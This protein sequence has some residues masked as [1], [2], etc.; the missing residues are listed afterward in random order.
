MRTLTSTR[1]I[2]MQTLKDFMPD[3][4]VGSQV[5]TT[6]RLE[7]VGSIIAV[8][9]SIYKDD[10]ISTHVPGSARLPADYAEGR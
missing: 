3:R 2:L 10:R 7:I 9:T 5:S 8:E 4:P 6:L 1:M